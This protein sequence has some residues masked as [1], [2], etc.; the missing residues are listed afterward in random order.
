MFVICLNI[1]MFFY[2]L[3]VFSLEVTQ[4]VSAYCTHMSTVER[5]P[6]QQALLVAVI[7]FSKFVILQVSL[8]IYP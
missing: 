4:S 3:V 5:I 1:D 8:M 2:D 6:H 7:N